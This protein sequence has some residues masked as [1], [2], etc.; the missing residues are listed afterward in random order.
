[1]QAMSAV[2]AQR[3][4]SES[5]LLDKQHHCCYHKLFQCLLICHLLK[6]L[7]II[8]QLTSSHNDDVDLVKVI[9]ITFFSVLCTVLI[10]EFVC[11]NLLVD[12]NSEI[13]AFIWDF[14]TVVLLFCL[15]F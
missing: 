5:K 4:S 9:N 8:Y 3:K 14:I 15:L 12:D 11:T 2:L 10:V 7:D 6:I 13:I 1:M